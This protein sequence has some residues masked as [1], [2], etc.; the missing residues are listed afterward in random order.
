MTLLIQALPELGESALGRLR[1]AFRTSSDERISGLLA[2]IPSLSGPFRL[3]ATGE[4]NAGKSS[5]LKALT[6]AEIPIHSDVTTSEVHEYSWH[7]VLLVDTPG[8]RAGEALHDERAEV[9][10]RDADLVVFVITVDLFD[11]AT[12]DHLRHVAFDLGKLEQM[13][14]V[15]N[16]AATM[17]AAPGV[18]D[19][20]V[21]E[22]LG[23]R[24][25]GA[26]VECDA[27][28][29][30]EAATAPTPDRAAYLAKRGNQVGLERALNDLV[31]T[32]A[33]VGRLKLPFEAALAAVADAQPLLAPEPDEEALSTLLDRRRQILAES[34]LRLGNR[35][36]QAFG[37]TRD[38][39]MAAGDALVA[40]ASE[41]AVP[42]AAVDEFE[43]EARAHAEALGEL[44]ARAFQ[45]ELDELT[46]E[47]RGLLQGPEMKT[48]FDAGL[49]EPNFDLP[50]GPSATS[51]SREPQSPFRRIISDFA[52]EHGR[53]WLKGAVQQGNRP[54]SPLHSI[55]YK[56]GKLGGHKF[57][58]WE[59]VKWAGRIQGA[60]VAGSYLFE[61]GSQVRALQREEGELQRHQHE[62][63]ALVREAA[64][65]LIDAA[66]EE[67]APT[68][69]QFFS[70]AGRS[71]TEIEERLD[72]LVSERVRLRG[73]LEDIRNDSRGALDMIA[74]ASSETLTR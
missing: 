26:L 70:E 21:R 3:V 24:W 63:R 47:E 61:F 64:D 41:D 66:R 20:A 55:V 56:L 43:R 8:V 69:A 45:R 14:I 62:L 60:L 36:E 11:D 16:K 58:P 2:R 15:V 49:L 30:L 13:V 72:S 48:I 22:V 40:A 31:T 32:Q 53:D 44:V 17:S 38:R 35:F 57:K 27:R 68:V 34:R 73:E 18:R 59:A 37:T 19:A 6:G 1:D 25:S 7:R 29:S 10:L 65:A 71:V 9:A 23:D 51:G 5:L 46:A 28:S 52:A 39:I 42:Q 33:N 54:G 50:M 4:Y 67:L 12:A 74:R